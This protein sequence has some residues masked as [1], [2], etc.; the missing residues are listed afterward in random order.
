MISKITITLF[1]FLSLFSIGQTHV[2]SISAMKPVM[3]GQDL[4]AHVQLD[5]IT[6]L[7]HLFAV[8]PLNRLQ[9]EVTIVNSEIFK[10]TVD[11]KGNIHTDIR[12][13]GTAPFI[14]YAQVEDWVSYSVK[15]TISSEKE[16]QELIE[17]L[18]KENGYDIEQAFPFIIKGQFDTVNFHI[19]SKPIKEKKHN[20]D[21]HNKAKKHFSKINIHG[22]LI[23]FFSKHD[24]GIFT[25]KGSFTHIH[26][27]D[28]KESMT[29]HLE[30]VSI[31]EKEFLIYF[32]AKIQGL[33]NITIK[34]LDTDFSKGRLT[35]EQTINLT[36]VVKFHG[37]LC[38][39]LTLGFIGLKEA[40]YTLFPDSIID[41]TNLRIVSKSSPCLTD[42]AVYLSGGRYQF[43]TFYVSDSI[44]Y[45]YIVQRIDNGKTIG[46][47]TIPGLVPTAIKEMGN[48]AVKGKL[49]SC[50]LDKL[51]KMEDDFIFQLINTL[52][53]E[54]FLIT[55]NHDF[56][57]SP[58]FTI[59]YK[60]TDVLNKNR[61]N[62]ES[63]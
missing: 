62:C 58:S 15:C 13:E 61:S 14:V 57:W 5:S 33:N 49:S 42:I 53:K 18:A 24:E 16:L 22:S 51:R 38:D 47:K 31:Q 36:D 8:C 59:T 27:L 11:K 7:P 56:I 2:K 45:L 35:N 17:K 39:G 20:H 55:E 52:P 29:G 10:S 4:S 28:D 40:L 50:D 44:D 32:P 60:K 23:G 9:G 34:T 48:Q 12:S 19:I 46:I 30:H 26:F 3:M 37:H 25:H 1:V 54:L 6:N 21:L 63:N 43:N 41:R